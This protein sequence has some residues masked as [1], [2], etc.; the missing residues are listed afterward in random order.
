VSLNTVSG[1]VGQQVELGVGDVQPSVMRAGRGV[2]DGDVLLVVEDGV[3]DGPGGVVEVGGRPGGLAARRPGLAVVDR[4][5][6]VDLGVRQGPEEAQL[7]D[8][9]ARSR[10]L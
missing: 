9:K 7:G 6:D 10:W 1:T 3:V 4:L 2:V 8:V 5:D